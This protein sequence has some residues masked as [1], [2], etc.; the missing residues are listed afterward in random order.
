MTNMTPQRRHAGGGF[1]IVELIVVVAIFAIVVATVVPSIGTF[2]DQMSAQQAYEIMVAQIGAAQAAAPARGTYTCVHVQRADG[3]STVRDA[4]NITEDI[5]Y[6]GIFQLNEVPKGDSADAWPAPSV[7]GPPAE[8]TDAGSTWM[9]F[10]TAPGYE[11]RRI[12]GSM[13]FGQVDSE[14]VSGSSFTNAAIS[15]LEDFTTFSIVFDPNGTLVRTVD[16]GRN[17]RF[18]AGDTM[19]GGTD[20]I[21]EPATTNSDPDGLPG[22]LGVRAFTIFRYPDIEGSDDPLSSLN[23]VGQFLPVM[24]Y[25]GEVFRRE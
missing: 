3:S 8:P 12:P 5:S 24:S 6:V 23:N 14:F 7:S 2:M 9:R 20:N 15:D 10:Q 18:D 22:E 16:A 11:A 19:F 4:L 1:T 21:W 25:T 17:P 13:A